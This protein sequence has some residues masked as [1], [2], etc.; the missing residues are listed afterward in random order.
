[1]GYHADIEIPCTDIELE[2][3]RNYI[4]GGFFYE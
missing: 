1:M 3:I 2:S 4:E